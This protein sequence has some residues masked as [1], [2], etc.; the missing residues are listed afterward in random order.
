MKWISS[1]KSS[2]EQGALCIVFGTYKPSW[3]SSSDHP[4]P[5]Q[6]M[7]AIY[8]DGEYCEFYYPYYDEL[9]VSHWVPLPEPPKEQ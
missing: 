3:S 6:V 2:P 5:A 7:I 8:E 4:R 9:N 1:A